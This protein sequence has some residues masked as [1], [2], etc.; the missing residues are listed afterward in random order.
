[1]GLN[2]DYL[3]GVIKR[4]K[5]MATEAKWRA[6]VERA[7][8][9]N[10]YV[11][12]VLN[13]EPRPPVPKDL[14]PEPP[15]AVSQAILDQYQEQL[16]QSIRE[17]QI[18]QLGDQF[19]QHGL[20]PPQGYTLQDLKRAGRSLGAD[21]SLPTIMAPE[22]PYGGLMN[23]PQPAVPPAPPD[24]L[25]SGLVSP[26]YM[27][28]AAQIADPPTSPVSP[29]TFLREDFRKLMRHTL[30]CV[31]CDPGHAK[32]DCPLCEGKGYTDED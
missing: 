13:D 1:M 27:R 16:F 8:E 11:R 30:H 23:P 12:A 3:D 21:M 25:S 24:P 7:Q 6:G 15:S 17:Q 4:R 2:P 31:V 19:G 14:F 5:K 9:V 20:Q 10:N 18:K 22:R 28:R 32:P 29:L 26:D